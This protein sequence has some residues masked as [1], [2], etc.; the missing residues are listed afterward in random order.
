MDKIA[1]LPA[2]L[3][4]RYAAWKSGD[5]KS[6]EAEFQRLV[7][8]GQ[9]PVAMVISC[10]DSRVHPN[11]MFMTEAGQFFV[12]R[13]IANLVP[14]FAPSQ[15]FHGTSAAVEYA[16]QVLEVPHLIIMGHSQCGGVKGCHD[17]C[18]GHAPELLE[19]SS[20]VGRWLDILSPSY[21]YIADIKDEDARLRAFEKRAVVTSL[22]NLLTFPFV[23][24]KREAG[25]LALHGLWT[26][27]ATGAMEFYNPETQAFEP[28]PV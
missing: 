15:N 12:H 25:K 18:A 8:E 26:D 2:D 23:R 7:E 20:F 9:S 6:S 14:P 5:F 16:V 1:P 17:M 3:V 28:V 10:C 19:N 11:Q 4:A 13:N 24:K 27:I 22:Q 21:G